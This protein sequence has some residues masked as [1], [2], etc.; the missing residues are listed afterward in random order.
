MMTAVWHNIDKLF[1]GLK[2]VRLKC[3]ICRILNERS[4]CFPMKNKKRAAKIAARFCFISL[5]PYKML[6]I[7]HFEEYFFFA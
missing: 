6:F 3:G 7:D 5:Y 4:F 1:Y 2:T